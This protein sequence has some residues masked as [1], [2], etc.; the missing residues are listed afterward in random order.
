MRKILLVSMV[1]AGLGGGVGLAEAGPGVSGPELPATV[2]DDRQPVQLGAGVTLPRAVF[3]QIMARA[4]GLATLE[5]M[6]QRA[7][8]SR[9]FEGVPHLAL[10]FLCVLVF[11]WSAMLYYQRKHARL[12][13]TI[14]LMV[15]K[16]VPLPPEILRAVEQFDA[17]DAQE[18]GGGSAKSDAPVWASN[19]LWGGLLWISAG[20]AGML[21]LWLRGSDA[22][23][24]GIAAILYGVVAMLVAMKNRPGSR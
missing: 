9:R 10:I 3:D 18:R 21:F 17:D 6:Q 20:I 24:W 8:N 15:E 19:L 11:F 13:H 12:H 7:E 23:P 14:Q 16:G 2:V 1:F 5:R 4:D 22:W